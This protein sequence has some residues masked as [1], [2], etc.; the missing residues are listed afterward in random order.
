MLRLPDNGDNRWTMRDSAVLMARIVGM[1][2][3]FLGAC[4]T[5]GALDFAWML[6]IPLGGAMI[7]AA[8][9]TAT[10]PVTDSTT[11][12]AVCAWCGRVLRD[13]AEPT[14]HGICPVCRD[15]LLERQP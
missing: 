1:V 11:M 9:W 5:V 3:F 12:R 2:V 8:E 14:T 4:P 6:G 15:R 10:S 7:L 13:G